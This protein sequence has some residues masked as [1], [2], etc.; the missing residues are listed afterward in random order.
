M[1]ILE[2]FLISIFYY[3]DILCN[4]GNKVEITYYAPLGVDS[5]LVHCNWAHNGQAISVDGTKYVQ[6]TS[7]SLRVHSVIGTD[8]GSY[9]C[10]YNYHQQQ[11][12]EHVADIFVLGE[13]VT[14]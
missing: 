8:E 4:Q 3:S 5:S 10:H 14:M 9:T 11:A 6:P 13:M 7:R 1:N 12:S 2:D